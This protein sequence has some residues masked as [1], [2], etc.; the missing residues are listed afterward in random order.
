MP[1]D[2]TYSPCWQMYFNFEAGSTS[3]ID[4]WTVDMTAPSSDALVGYEGQS[5][6]WL[7]VRG[8]AG[9]LYRRVIDNP[10]QPTVEAPGEDG[11]M[12]RRSTDR[13]TGSFQLTV[14][15]VPGATVLALVGSPADPTAGEP[16]RDLA[17]FEVTTP[18]GGPSA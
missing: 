18:E 2:P 16:A 10:M 7:E 5:G 3:L 9:T 1:D 17:T 14:P 11:Q 8:D 15:Q 13:Q 6:F 4:S 12:I